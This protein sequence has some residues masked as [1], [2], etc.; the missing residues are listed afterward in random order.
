MFLVSKNVYFSKLFY[1]FGKNLSSLVGF[2]PSASRIKQVLSGQ[3]FN[4]YYDLIR[5]WQ[6]YKIVHFVFSIQSKT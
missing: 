3:C 1:S 5:E 2:L 4:P 6:F